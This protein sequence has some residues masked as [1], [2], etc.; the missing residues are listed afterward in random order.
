MLG[1]MTKIINVEHKNNLKKF[2]TIIIQS[3]NVLLHE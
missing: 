3:E 1:I 2:I